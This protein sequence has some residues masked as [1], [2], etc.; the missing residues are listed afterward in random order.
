MLL[1]ENVFDGVVSLLGSDSAEAQGGQRRKPRVTLRERLTLLPCP[2]GLAG[3]IGP[4]LSV[5]VRNVSRG[6]VRFLLPRRLPLDTQFILLLPR[7]NTYRL[8][9]TRDEG[10]ANFNADDT[11]AVLCAVAYW[12]PLGKDLFAI[13]AQ[14][15][16]VLSSADL[17]PALSDLIDSL[18]PRIVL[19]GM[20]GNESQAAELQRAAS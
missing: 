1:S 10:A 15:T 2:E 19:A 3:P 11:I 20:A 6:G 4:P 9:P 17:P 18:E 7:P 14:F 8:F 12:Q 13:G 16:H 5:P